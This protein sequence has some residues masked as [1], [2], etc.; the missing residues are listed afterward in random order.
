MDVQEKQPPARISR[1]RGCNAPP[2]D[3]E[4]KSIHRGSSTVPIITRPWSR[5]AGTRILISTT[6]RIGGR[7]LFCTAVMGRTSVLSL[8]HW[9]PGHEAGGS[10]G[11]QPCT[12][13][14]G[15]H[16]PVLMHNT[17]QQE[18]VERCGWKRR[19]RRTF[20]FVFDLIA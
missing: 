5:C 4:M 6:R 8:L 10:G 9:E 20:F 16:R 1:S 12:L 19:S 7:G 18:A 15:F 17:G 11:H 3:D 2:V 13:P 14:I